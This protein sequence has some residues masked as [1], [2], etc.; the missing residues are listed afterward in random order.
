MYEIASDNAFAMKENARIVKEIM[1]RILK[2][3]KLEIERGFK[4]YRSR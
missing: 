2:T 1:K 3:E 4:L